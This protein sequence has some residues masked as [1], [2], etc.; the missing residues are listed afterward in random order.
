MFSLI[1]FNFQLIKSKSNEEYVK[2]LLIT[3]ESDNGTDFFKHVYTSFGKS[4]GS[5]NSFLMHPDSV[6]TLSIK[7]IDYVGKFN[8]QSKYAVLFEYLDVDGNVQMMNVVYN[9]VY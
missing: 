4:E 2:T 6:S 9:Q 8:Y 5:L 1:D 7:S 3:E